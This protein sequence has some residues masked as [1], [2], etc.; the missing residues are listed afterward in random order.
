MVNPSPVSDIVTFCDIKPIKF[1]SQNTQRQ[2]EYLGSCRGLCQ[3]CTGHACCILAP[4]C[5][6]FL[7][8]STL[9][10]HQK[11]SWELYFEVFGSQKGNLLL[12]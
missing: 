9:F 8:A 12:Q 6:Y 2:R 10:I 4:F 11:L 3:G 5:A 1:V 7:H